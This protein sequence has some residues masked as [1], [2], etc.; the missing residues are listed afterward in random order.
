MSKRPNM[1]VLQHEI[2]RMK[3]ARLIEQK[4][5]QKE[6]IKIDCRTYLLKRSATNTIS[7]FIASKL[8]VGPPIFIASTITTRRGNLNT[9]NCKQVTQYES[10]SQHE[11]RS[12]KLGV[13]K[14]SPRR[15]KLGLFDVVVCWEVFRTAAISGLADRLSEAPYMNFTAITRC[16]VKTLSD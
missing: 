8:D 14:R 5:Y 1:K 3:S 2:R 15:E 10:K 7:V 9:S 4:R 16:M 12:T 13:V 6:K 11:T